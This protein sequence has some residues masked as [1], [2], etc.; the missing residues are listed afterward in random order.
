MQW[1]PPNLT[2]LRRVRVVRIMSLLQNGHQ[3]GLHDPHD[4][5]HPKSQLQHTLR[6]GRQRVYQQLQDQHQ[7]LFQQLRDQQQFQFQQ[8]Q[9]QHQ[10][11]Q[12][13][14]QHQQEQVRNQQ[15]RCRQ[16]HQCLLH[17]NHLLLNLW[18]EIQQTLLRQYLQWYHL[19]IHQIFLHRSQRHI[20]QVCR[21]LTRAVDLL[22]CLHLYQ[23]KH[24]HL[25]QQ[26]HPNPHLNTCQ[27][28]LLR[29]LLS[30]RHLQ[31]QILPLHRVR[32]LP[33]RQVHHQL[34]RQCLLLLL[35]SH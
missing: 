16:S 21:L 4:G 20:R 32:I 31:V 22:P 34:H 17:R 1:A 27:A 11:Q 6:R 8:L 26:V 15:R 10:L 33:R 28:H 29:S 35:Q 19:L 7:F 25:P 24:L 30:R 13:R 5:L 14:N 23:V 3:I 2:K 9:D 18:M 12:L